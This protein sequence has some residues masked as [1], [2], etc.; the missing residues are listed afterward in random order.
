MADDKQLFFLYSDK[1]NYKSEL[2]GTQKKFYVEGDISTT[3]PDLVNDVVSQK[4]LDDMYGQ[5][6]T[7]S[8]KLDFEHEAFLGDSPIEMERAKTKSP[9]G[10][11]TMWQ[12]L[13]NSVRVQW[14]LNPNWQRLDSKGNVIKSFNEIWE[15]IK[16]GFLDAFSIAYIPLHTVNTK[17]KNGKSIRLLDSVNLLNVALTGNPVNTEAKMVS[18]FAKSRD[19][20]ENKNEV[21]NMADNIDAKTNEED[22]IKEN[23]ETTETTTEPTDTTTETTTE[24]TTEETTEPEQ[25][26]TEN[27]EYIEIKSALKNAEDRLAAQ[28]K[29]IADLKSVVEKAR[30]KAFGAEDNSKKSDGNIKIQGLGPLDNI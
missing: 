26:S 1:L 20:L 4:C 25:K 13:K 2:S 5:L 18:I 12:R 11:R 23:I 9:L 29:E 7:R 22:K 15:E 28:D 6:E 24:K 21:D 14:E 27:K 10:K 30:L 17:L 16:G 3:D 19:Y 8:I